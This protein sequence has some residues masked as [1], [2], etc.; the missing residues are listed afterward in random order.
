MIHKGYTPTQIGSHLFIELNMED[1]LSLAPIPINRDSHLRVQKRKSDF[2][3][4]Y[5]VHREEQLLTLVAVGIVTEPF[6]DKS[7]KIYYKVGDWFCMDGNTRLHYWKQN[8]ER[9]SIHKTV[10]AEIKYIRN[11][12]DVEFYYYS[13]DNN[14][15]VEKSTEI[16]QGLKN[17]YNWSPRQTMFANGGY[18]TALDWASRTPG[19]DRK[20]VHEQFELCFDALKIMDRL[21]SK[22]GN[23]NNT[24]TNPAFKP[25]K[26]QAIIAAFLLA[27]RY[28]PNN[29]TLHDMIDQICT[30]SYEDLRGYLL[31]GSVSP[32]HIIMAEYGDLSHE[33]NE[34]LRNN[35]QLNGWLNGIA[36]S[37][38]FATQIPQM[39]FLMYWIGQYIQN[40]KKS[41]NFKKLHFQT[42]NE[43]K[44]TVLIWKDAWDNFHPKDDEDESNEYDVDKVLE[45]LRNKSTS[46][47]IAESLNLA[48]DVNRRNIHDLHAKILRENGSLA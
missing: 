24:I 1:F 34:N 16:L 37:T 43:N 26:S 48:Q 15:A 6:Y 7:A 45:S 22:T 25:M 17:R 2:D 12:K 4:A 9:A 8:P 11:L 23:H 10:T 36:R 38:S 28:H 30:T 32:V 3:N 21:P 5:L 20:S 44:E 27:L 19:S 31:N 42:T 14:R 40:P 13:Y 41:F 39:D 33:R 35:P 29:T 18:T 47:H 46:E